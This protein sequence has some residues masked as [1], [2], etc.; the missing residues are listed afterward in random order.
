LLDALS[1]SVLNTEEIARNPAIKI[2][3][4]FKR[5]LTGE[6]TQLDT[7][8]TVKVSQTLKGLVAVQEE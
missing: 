1:E 3:E 2:I 5:L 6:P 8:N 7:S 4:Y